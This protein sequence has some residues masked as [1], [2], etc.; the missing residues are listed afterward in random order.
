V[1]E[2]GGRRRRS[3]RWTL[4]T[5]IVGNSGSG[6]TTLARRLA[7]A[8]G[9]AVLSLDELAWAEGV[10]R[11][12]AADA[13]AD[14]R[15]FIDRH[16]A[17]VI[18][19]CYGD[20]VDAAASDADELRWLDPGVEVCLAHC[21]ARPWEPDKFDSPEA[22]QDHFEALLDWVRTY[23]TRDDEFGLAR[24]RAIFDGFPGP[25]RRYR[26]VAEYDDRPTVAP[27]R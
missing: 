5:L 23:P 24:H 17:W 25:K 16:D 2:A 21:R 10:T 9:A 19:G 1:T 27:V 11:R 3:A 26:A 14:V 12:P 15:R 6:K 18:E 8:G 7:G 20:V 13:V 22:Q 4:R